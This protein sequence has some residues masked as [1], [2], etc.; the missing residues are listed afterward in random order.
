MSEIDLNWV[1]E[2]L[3]QG[4]TKRVVGDSVIHLLDQVKNLP[5]MSESDFKSSIEIFSK[6]ALG[7]SLVQENKNEKWVPVMP[8]QIKVADE[9]RVKFDA[10]TGDA[11]ML[12]NG[13]RGRIVAVRSGDIIFKSTDG[14]EPLIDGAHY[15]AQCLEKLV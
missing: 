1:K 4:K 10:F 14:K 12:N 11:G 15:V 8:G 7:H 3:T 9:V 6:L 5:K 13:R 2:Q